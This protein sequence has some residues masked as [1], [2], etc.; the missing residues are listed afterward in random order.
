MTDNPNYDWTGLAGTAVERLRAP[1]VEPVP[2][3]IVQLAQQSWD[4]VGEGENKL[5]VLR[6]EFGDAETAAEF[7]R[8]A[9]KAGEHTTPLTSVTAVIDPDGNDNLKAVTIKA[10]VRRGRATTN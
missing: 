4:G 2:E 10:G 6:F 5:H 7:A 8:L 9:R 3:P 1:K